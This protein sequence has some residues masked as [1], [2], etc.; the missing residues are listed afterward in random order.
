M[1]VGTDH[2]GVDER[3]A[4]PRT[5]MGHR[6]DKSR[7]RGY[8]IGSVDFFKMEIGESSDQP[9][10]IPPSCLHFH[11]YRNRVSVVLNHKNQRQ[12]AIG[13]GVHG[14]PELAFAGS[15]VSER[16]VSHLIGMERHILKLAI[17]A[18]S[19]FGGFGMSS[20]VARG[21]GAAH[22]L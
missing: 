18:A 10:D 5:T 13:G 2:V 7:I 12:A 14:F 8:W 17:V 11:R 21:F 20:Q 19:L 22:S 1:R 16:N 6:P 3:R 4:I 9:R 15:A